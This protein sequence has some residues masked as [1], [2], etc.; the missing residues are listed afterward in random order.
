VTVR[1][2]LPASAGQ[3]RRMVLQDEDGAATVVTADQMTAVGSSAGEGVVAEEYDIELA[4]L[5]PG[6]HGFTVEGGT[7]PATA[8]VVVAPRCPRPPRGWGAFAPLTAVR[9]ET[10][11][12]VGTYPELAELCRWV[13]RAGGRFVGTL[14]LFPTFLDHPVEPSPYLPVTRL[15][16]S[17]LFIDPVAVPEATTSPEARALLDSSAT[18]AR[19]ATLRAAAT[20]DYGAVMAC[21]RTVLEPMA[22]SV[23]ASP[24]PR[25]RALVAFASLRP[26]LVA[27]ARFRSA[28]ERGADWS[29]VRPQPS[30]PGSDDLDALDDGARY[31]LYVQWVAHAQLEAAEGHLYLDA[32]VG[33]HPDGFDAW[34]EAGSFVEGMEGG[35]PPDEFFAGGQTWGFRPLHPRRVRQDG[36]R[37]PIACLR[38]VMQAASM[39]R[40]DHVMGLHRLY[41]VPEGDAA[42]HGV[43][44]RY[45]LD[46]MQAVV[47]LEAHRSGTAVVGED[48]G[49]VPDLVRESMATSGMLRS[50]VLEFE[51]SPDDPLPDPPEACLA[52]VGT[53]DLPRFASFWDGSDIDGLVARGAQSERWAAPERA[54]RRSW[55]EA[56]T[57]RDTS[58]GATAPGAAAGDAVGGPP[59]GE[60]ASA[61]R[62]C[63]GHL[64]ASAARVTMIDLEDLWLEPGQVNR[65]GAGP[66]AGNWLGR[67][68]RS[69]DQVRRDPGVAA[70][71]GDLATRRT[72]LRAAD[73]GRPGPGR[74]PR[75]A[76]QPLESPGV[77]P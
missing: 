36:Y 56:L 15:G 30:R 61:L 9:S 62:A 6:Y 47:A 63:L 69:L 57:G 39:V 3:P 5:R 52:S 4:S 22:H 73:E 50:W 59:A 58:A 23:F 1:V 44:V 2:R 31:H 76:D 49:T 26:E 24:S 43:Y 71:L 74:G 65:P 11:W 48:L 33:V 67:W 10:N 35:A 20:V 41:W 38:Q 42:D 28:H 77:R 37:Y 19:V 55:R 29:G 34:W 51:V 8:T 60:A 18:I 70:L 66:G 46:E 25:R 13:G 45:H 16:W 27:Y 75:R 72:A 7:H 68:S 14:P 40:I 21:L 32:P 53:H 54:R 17:E 64:A 12:G